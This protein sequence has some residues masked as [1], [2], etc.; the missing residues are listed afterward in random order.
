MGRFGYEA[1][2]RCEDTEMFL[3]ASA[4][5]KRNPVTVLRNTSA[6]LAQLWN[7]FSAIPSKNRPSQT[8]FVMPRT[9]AATSTTTPPTASTRLEESSQPLPDR[10]CSRDAA[11]ALSGAA[12]TPLSRPWLR[13]HL[14]PRRLRQLFTCQSRL[15]NNR[16]ANNIAL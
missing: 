7:E 10:H 3:R 4:A 14:L 13:W 1:R 11:R 15:A 9:I 5:S 12:L 16:L 8:A 6:G 2:S